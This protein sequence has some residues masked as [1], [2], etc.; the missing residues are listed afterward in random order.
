MRY[1]LVVKNIES[2]EAILIKRYADT[3][4][5]SIIRLN[6]N[7]RS[8]LNFY[9]RTDELFTKEERYSEEFMAALFD[10]IK[11]ERHNLFKESGDLALKWIPIVT[12]DT[13]SEFDT[14]IYDKVGEIK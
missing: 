8:I 5:W 9:N 1:V 2:K 7:E 12:I 10:T 14:I 11:N 6:N 13:V 4:K 3:D